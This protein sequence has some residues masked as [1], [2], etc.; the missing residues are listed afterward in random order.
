[1]TEVITS[2]TGSG[3]PQ[4][5]AHYLPCIDWWHSWLSA[6]MPAFTHNQ[7]VKTH[8]GRIKGWE[9]LAHTQID[10]PSGTLT[11]TIPTQKL[12]IPH[13]TIADIRISNHGDW[14]H[15]HCHALESTYYNSPYFEYY[16]DQFRAIYYADQQ[17][18]Y[19]LNEQLITLV[20]QLLHL[21]DN[22]LLAALNSMEQPES[23]GQNTECNSE[24]YQ[25][26]SHKHAFIPNLSIV[27]L[28]FNQG[29]ESI[30]Y[31]R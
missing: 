10:S 22:S 12:Y 19:E 15:K 23:S 13:P 11:L 31:L 30:L 25:V 2:S 3:H 1:M 16:Y 9:Q 4:W 5:A 24:Y 8:G 27:D 26:F 7:P 29:P 20:T 21:D 28:L 14:R 18:L 6:G 17:F